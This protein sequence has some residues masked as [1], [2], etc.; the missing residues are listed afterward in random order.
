MEDTYKLGG[1]RNKE[2]WRKSP[3]IICFFQPMEKYRIGVVE[4]WVDPLFAY[5]M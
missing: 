5:V 4:M 2:P 1:K 3:L